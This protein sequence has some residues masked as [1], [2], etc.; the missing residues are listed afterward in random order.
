MDGKEKIVYIIGLKELPEEKIK[1]SEKINSCLI[2]RSNKIPEDAS[3]L[4]V[5]LTEEQEYILFDIEKKEIP[6]IAAL[7]CAE[8]KIR[9]ALDRGAVDFL[10]KDESKNYIKIFPHYLKHVFSHIEIME[11]YYEE[12]HIFSELSENAIFG[13]YVFGK[14]LKFRYVNPS[15]LKVFEFSTDEV[16]RKVDVLSIIH[17]D[18]KNFVREKIKSRFEGKEKIAEYSFRIIDKKGEIKWVYAKGFVTE[19]YGEEVIMGTLTDI[20]DLKKYQEEIEKEKGEIEETLQDG[21][22][23]LSKIVEVK[24]PYTA[25]HQVKVAE[26][27][28]RVAKEFNFDEEKLNE[29]LWAGLLHDIG[30]ISVPSEILSKPSKLTDLEYSLIKQHCVAGYKILKEIHR[31]EKIAEIIW[32]HHE[33]LDGSGYPRGLKDGEIT[34]EARLLAVADVIE[35]MRTHRPYRPARSKEEIMKELIYGKGEK[36]DPKIVDVVIN[37]IKKGEIDLSPINIVE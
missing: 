31:M 5:D 11:Q 29:I 24:D 8:K 37:L 32:Q 16:Y 34:L 19:F 1:K 36:Y 2:K 7:E 35:A 27:A 4:I 30:K 6:F 12:K 28:E 3:L 13:I 23:A 10:I 26:I 33:R 17:P 18:D 25:S 15:L 20:T 22:Y 9:R 21:V 14:D